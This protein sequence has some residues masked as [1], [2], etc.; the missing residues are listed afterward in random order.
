MINFISDIFQELKNLNLYSLMLD[1]IKQNKPLLQQQQN[2][3][4]KHIVDTF[5]YF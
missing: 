4:Q 1:I 3:H 5:R 2:R